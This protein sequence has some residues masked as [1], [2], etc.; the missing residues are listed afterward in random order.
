MSVQVDAPVVGSSRLSRLYLESGLG[1][2]FVQVMLCWYKYSIVTNCISL[3]MVWIFLSFS[4]TYWSNLI[5]VSTETEL[6]QIDTFLFIILIC[7]GLL[8]IFNSHDVITVQV[9]MNQLWKQIKHS[10]TSKHIVSCMISPV[11]AFAHPKAIM[12]ICKKYSL[13][14]CSFFLT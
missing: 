12:F 2:G 3:L 14:L 7:H 4:L 9:H 13:T 8:A 10:L 11:T 1:H 6:S 5:Y